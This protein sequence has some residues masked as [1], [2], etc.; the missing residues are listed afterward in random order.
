LVV[1]H[2]VHTEKVTGIPSSPHSKSAQ[3][4]VAALQNN[5]LIRR[6]LSS[7]DTGRRFFVIFVCSSLEVVSIIS[8][9]PC[10]RRS[11]HC[12]EFPACVCFASPVRCGYD[13]RWRETGQFLFRIEGLRAGNPLRSVECLQ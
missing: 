11:I 8:M 2:L 4:Y 7:I 5:D 6:P 1:E 3:S 13:A 10:P 12:G 9:L